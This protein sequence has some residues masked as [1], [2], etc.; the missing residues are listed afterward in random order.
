MLCLA[1]IM[2]HGNNLD[3]IKNEIDQKTNKS[4]DIAKIV[5]ENTKSQELVDY[6][7]QL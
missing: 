3:Q 6:F 5:I 1:M 2:K 4:N 7:E